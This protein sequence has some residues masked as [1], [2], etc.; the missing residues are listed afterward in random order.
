MEA[1]FNNTSVV[2]E[3][4]CSWVPQ[5]DGRG[6]LD[7]IVSC[8]ITIFLCSW[9]CICVNVPPPK[10]SQFR[11][12][13]DKWHLFCLNVLGPE[14]VFMLALGQYLSARKSVEAFHDSG[15]T[16]WTITHAFYADMGGFTF[17]PRGWK[18]FPVNSKELHYLVTKGYLPFPEVTKEHI[19]DKDKASGLARCIDFFLV[20]PLNSVGSFTDVSAI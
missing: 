15:Y 10:N 14:F 6:T 18:S 9:T 19:Q 4:L 20:K 11:Q 12:F 5:P 2:E 17:Q 13:L 16:G 8:V 3:E 7:I 1:T